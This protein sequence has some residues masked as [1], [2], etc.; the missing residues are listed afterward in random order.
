MKIL[1]FIFNLSTGGAEKFTVDLSNQL[2]LSNDVYLCVIQNEDNQLNFFKEQINQNV[3]YINLN[4]AK[5][6]NFKTFFT[7]FKLCKTIKPDVIHSH[8]NTILYLYLPA[9]LFKDKI[10]FVHTLHSVAHKIASFKWQ[11]NINSFFYK[12]NLIK[13]V[14]ISKENKS[15]FIEF[16]HYNNVAIIE[17]GVADPIKTKKFNYVKEEL[18]E[19]KFKYSDKIFIHIG[20]FSKPKNQMLLI[21][22][23]NKLI[24]DDQNVI[25]IIIGDYFDSEGAKKLREISNKRIYYLGIRVNISDY[26]LNSDIFVLSSL[27]EGLPISLLEALSC[28]TIPVCTPAGGIPDVIKDESIGYISKDFS[29]KELYY[30][31]QK[32]IKN[33]DNFEKRE[34]IDYF[35][36]S[37]SMNKCAKKYLDFYQS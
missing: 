14:V 12:K 9:L 6:I 23:F 16:Y 8:L 25:L 22:V 30:T 37:F 32:C 31:V 21:K 34:I 5:G 24:E 7:I 20:R 11:K 4:C 3:K 33:Y 35:N 36:T 26:L 29:E 13:P 17:N 28:G 1:Q 27:W 15:S 19:L 10:I 2:S 18:K